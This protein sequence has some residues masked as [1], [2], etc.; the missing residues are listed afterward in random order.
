MNILKSSDTFR[1]QLLS[2]LQTDC[3]Y[4]LGNGNRNCNSL[5]AENENEQIK[6]MKELWESFSSTEK[7]E[8]LTW[9][10]ILTLESR[11]ITNSIN[12]H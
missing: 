8:W 10:D 5:W 9:G 7:P 6:T 4:Y 1:Y 3:N 12:R 11:M 2:R